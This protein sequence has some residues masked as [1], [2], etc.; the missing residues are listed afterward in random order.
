[1]NSDF[2]YHAEETRKSNLLLQAALL[3]EQGRYER[4]ATLFAEAAAIEERLAE[5]AEAK[6][7]V[8]RALRHRFS[9]ASGWAQAGDFY[10]ALALL[11]SLEERADAPPALRERIQAFSQV[12]N[13]QR[14]RWSFALREASLT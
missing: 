11:H 5:S 13:E 7:D 6:G 9:A 10:H 14:E 12:V 3:R 8:S 2:D 1:M 4:A